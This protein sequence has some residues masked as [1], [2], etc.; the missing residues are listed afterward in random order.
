MTILNP[1]TSPARVLAALRWQIMSANQ[2]LEVAL[3]NAL[4]YDARM[5][6][7]VPRDYYKLVNRARA[8]TRRLYEL[9]KTPGFERA[10]LGK[11]SD[12]EEEDDIR[13]D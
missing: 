4:Y 9:T 1:S 8:S 11:R 5:G 12:E 2:A 6:N 7:V 13:E 10:I 3:G